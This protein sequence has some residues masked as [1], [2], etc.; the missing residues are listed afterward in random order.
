MSARALVVSIHDVS[1]F[2]GESVESILEGLAEVGI[3]R[4]SLLVVP[5]HH[6]RGNITG[7]PGF[8][9]WLRDLVAAGNEPVLHGYFHQRE[10][11][12]HESGWTRL[13]TRYYTADEGEFFDIGYDTAR[14]VLARG[15]EELAQ[16]AGV[17][18]V[19]FIAPAWLLSAEGERAAGD[20]GFGYTTRLKS[21]SEL[22]THRAHESQSLCWSVRG[23]WRGV[24]SLGWNRV[25]FQ[26]LR[27]NRLLRI[28]IHPPDFGHREV[29]RQILG[30]ARRALEDREAVTY[31][32]CVGGGMGK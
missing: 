29:W 8:G 15:R 16:A 26:D 11:R 30:L 24:L 2:T 4:V 32:D 27:G 20:L 6:R 31:R 7:D 28:S 23:N 1:P 18:P 19:G 9:A 25:L 5:D 10:R 12:A 17:A 14:G 21:V 3:G 13:V 22:G